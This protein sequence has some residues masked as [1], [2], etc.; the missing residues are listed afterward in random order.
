MKCEQCGFIVDALPEGGGEYLCPN[1]GWCMR[2]GTPAVPA[3]G[4]PSPTDTSSGIGT[5]THL[6]IAKTVNVG[7]GDFASV[8]AATDASKIVPTDTGRDL[9]RTIL[10]R[11]VW[12]HVRRQ[13]LVYQNRTF[14]FA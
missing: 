1:C 13:V 9:E 8:L 10:A 12:H 6:K 2:K 3:D 5:A 14:V 7:F 11:A 4:A